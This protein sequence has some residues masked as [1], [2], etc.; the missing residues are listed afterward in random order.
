MATKQTV[1]RLYKDMLRDAARVESYNYRNYAVRRVREEFR[2]NKALSAGSAEQ[3][4]A[5]AFAKEQAGV[6][7]RQ[8]V[9]TKLYP[10]QT[11]S[12]MEQA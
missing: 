8:M 4:Q 10:P 6:L 2:K 5:L 9:I 12:I 1:L 7:H 3:Q 11:K